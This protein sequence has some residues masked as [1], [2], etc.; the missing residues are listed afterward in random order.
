MGIDQHTMNDVFICTAG[1]VIQT[2]HGPI[3]AVFNQAAYHGKGHSIISP[4]Q[5]EHFGITVD[6]KSRKAGGTQC[7]VTPD[8]YVIPLAIRN[9][10]PYMS[11]RPYTDAEWETLPHVILTSDVEWDPRALDYDPVVQDEDWV[12][13]LRQ[14]AKPSPHDELFCDEGDYRKVGLPRVQ[15]YRANEEIDTCLHFFDATDDPS[16][17]QPMAQEQFFD[18][19]DGDDDDTNFLL[20]TNEYQDIDDLIEDDCIICAQ[21]HNIKASFGGMN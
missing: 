19:E 13:T 8:G 6:D 15:R 12:D 3:I 7:I 2:Q 18:A 17:V 10:L 11:M 1:A 16:D 21:Y 4:T 5:L 14:Y 20:P 9:G